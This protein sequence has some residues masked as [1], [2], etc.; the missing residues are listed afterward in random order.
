MQ[1]T[2]FF[3]K[4]DTQSVM[5]LKTILKCFELASRLKVNYSKSKVDGVSVSGNQIIGF[6][7]ILN[8][9]IM[10][11]HFTYLGMAVGGNHKR[12]AFWE[13][14]LSKLQSRLGLWNGK[15]LS[16]SGRFCL[17]KSVLNSL[18]LFYM[19]IFRITVTLMKEVEMIQKNFYE[20]GTQREEKLSG[21][22]E[23]RYVSRK[24]KEV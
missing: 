7:T 11:T 17:T 2:L 20:I 4:A 24:K 13:G 23:I 9:E 15:F 5:T 1:M 3:C 16:L 22:R 18:L 14:V 10:K 19:S 21:L 8:C 12:C 6:V